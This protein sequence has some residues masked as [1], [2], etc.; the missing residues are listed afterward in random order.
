MATTAPT[1]VQH[2]LAALERRVLD[3]LQ[4]GDE[5]PGEAT[6]AAELSCSRLTVREAV[7]TLAARG[8]V[9]VRMGRR[10]VVR[11]PD[12]LAVGHFFRDALRRDETV[13]LQLLEVRQALETDAAALA[14]RRA[15]GADLAALD[16]AIAAMEGSADAPE[17]FHAAD[18]RFHEALAAAAANPLLAELVRH[19]ADP[20]LESRRLSW[21]GRERDG[22]PVAAVLDAHRAIAE[23]VRLRDPDGAAAAMRV[24]LDETARDLGVT[25]DA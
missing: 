20:L 12:G 1:A 2:A 18:V 21:A 6:L 11:R 10:T 5:L 15:R 3:D 7:R 16:E 25:P 24:H 17:A 13:L 23:C 19:L 8:L 22:R 14:A 4:P 9:D